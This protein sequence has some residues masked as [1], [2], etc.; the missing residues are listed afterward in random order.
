MTTISAKVPKRRTPRRYTAMTAPA[1]AGNG[2]KT[3]GTKANGPVANG[4]PTNGAGANGTRANGSAANGSAA[5]GSSAKRRVDAPGALLSK[6]KS[7]LRCATVADIRRELRRRLSDMEQRRDAL[8][9]QLHAVETAIAEFEVESGLT[10]RRRP[11][12]GRPGNGRAQRDGA[13]RHGNAIRLVDALRRI[14]RDR[15]LSVT[16]M[17]AAV[18]EAGY[19]TTSPNFRTIVNQALIN[20]T[21]VFRRV[22]RGKYT[23]R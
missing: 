21:D 18:Q 2:T 19:R 5:N 10:A 3:N 14:L 20:H 11:T 13:K 7:A 12:F 6:D 23:A 15:T 22:S 16:E 9:R 1:A 4:V 17:A 8:A